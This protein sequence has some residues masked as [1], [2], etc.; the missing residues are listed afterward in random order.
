MHAGYVSCQEFDFTLR[1][2]PGPKH[3]NAD[4][5][6]RARI[7]E[8]TMSCGVNDEIEC[9]F[10]AEVEEDPFT[11][12]LLI[13]CG[14]GKYTCQGPMSDDV[15]VQWQRCCIWFAS[16]STLRLYIVYWSL[17]RFVLSCNGR[18]LGA[19]DLPCMKFSKS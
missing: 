2:R 15:C 19:Q 12:A 5:L 7:K 3:G 1:Y 9:A 16:G 8:D 17:A 13:I 14:P 4:G 10:R 18:P 11:G 6:S